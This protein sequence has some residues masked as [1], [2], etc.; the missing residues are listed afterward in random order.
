VL[1]IGCGDGEA[2]LFLAREFPRARVR[3]VDA[4]EA[5]IGKAIARVGLDPEGRV[6]FKAARATSLPYPDDFFDLV[7]Q[8]DARPAAAEIRR[9]LRPGGYAILARSRRSRGLFRQT[10]GRLRRHLERHGIEQIEAADAGD[11][12]FFVG[13]LSDGV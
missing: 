11:G 7:A 6:A 12:N 13:R 4:S 2:A 8:L 5:L 10:P 1:V 9:V 3:G